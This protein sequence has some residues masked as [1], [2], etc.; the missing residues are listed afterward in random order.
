M[1]NPLHSLCPY[2]AMFP[3]G[4]VREHVEKL[5][6]EGDYV[7]DPFS[8]RGTTLLESLI[9]N[10]RAAAMDINPVAYCVS[11]AKANV[12]PL[13]RILSRVTTMEKQYLNADRRSLESE[14]RALPAFFRRAFYH[15]TLRQI[16]FLRREL[17]WRNNREDRFITALVLGSLHGEND[18]SP[19]Y[20]SNQMPRTI[21]TKPRYSLKYWRERNLWPR[22]REVFR[23]LLSRAVHR[24]SSDAPL[25][26]GLVRLGDA[27]K[28]AEAF[29][30][31]NEKINLIITS[32]PYLNVT[33]Y[34]EDQWLRLWF[35]GCEPR[36][37]YG[38]ISKD[39]RHGGSEAYWDFLA[40]VWMG[41]KPL[42]AYGARIVCRIG[43]K[44]I[45]LNEVTG[46]LSN[47]ICLARPN[48]RLL[49]PPLVSTIKNRQTN[50]FRPGSG[51]CVV[52]VDY[53]FAG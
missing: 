26:S 19:S 36:P 30:E 33:N 16:L 1:R 29:P 45:D 34:E 53:V 41:V 52:E 14:R 51:G 10:R 46:R 28:A 40:D 4:F 18:K 39:D 42:L 49:Y 23:I 8:G 50:V 32:P 38:K 13:E 21:S 37:T 27:R 6:A 35:L 24:L 43:S 48:A 20:F 2:F 5:S 17:G 47:C 15:T 9:L 11:A 22:K 44:D 25:G 7:F 3:E 31:L 12:P